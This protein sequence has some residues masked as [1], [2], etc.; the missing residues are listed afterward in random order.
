MIPGKNAKCVILPFPWIKPAIAEELSDLKTREFVLAFMAPP[1]VVR[2]PGICKPSVWDWFT[3]KRV[4]TILRLLVLGTCSLSCLDSSKLIVFQK[5]FEA[6][7]YLSKRMAPG[8][9]TRCPPEFTQPW[10]AFWPSS[11]TLGAVT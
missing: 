1:S 11:G 6:S 2:V 8:D 7:S 4:S 9:V 10:M 5:M 3:P